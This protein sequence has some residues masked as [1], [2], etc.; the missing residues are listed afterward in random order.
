MSESLD[1]D[2]VSDETYRVKLGL[3][4]ISALDLLSALASRG[5]NDAAAPEPEPDKNLLD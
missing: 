3:G 2:P 5:T 4:V 1:P